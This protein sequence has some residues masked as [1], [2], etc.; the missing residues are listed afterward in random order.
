MLKLNKDKTKLFVFSFG[1]HVSKTDNLPIE[2]G[3]SYIN[4]SMSLRHIELI[5][6][7][8]IGMEKQVNYVCKS[9]YYQIR[10]IRLIHKYINYETCKTLIQALII[11]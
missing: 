6:D 11:S 10:N 4:T 5:S 2:V 1:Q 9:S 3:F 7:N 8:I